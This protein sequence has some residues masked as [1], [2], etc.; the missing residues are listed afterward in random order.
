MSY[1]PQ[2]FHTVWRWTKAAS[3]LFLFALSGCSDSSD[4]TATPSNGTTP[5]EANPTAQAGSSPGVRFADCPFDLTRASSDIRCGVLDTY[6]NYELTGP[7]ARMIEV[8]FGIV[9]ATITPAAPDPIVVFMG[10]PGASGLVEFALGLE[11]SSYSG[12]RDLVLVDQRGTGYSEP[13]LNCDFPE[14]DDSNDGAILTE[15]VKDFEQQGVDLTQYRSAV[16][17][18]DFKVL[19]EALEIPQ[20]NVYG[21][22]YGPIPGVLYADLDRAGVRSVIFDSSTDNQVDIMLAD[23]ASRLDFISELAD[24]CAAETECATRLP[25]LR[26]AFIDT[27]RSLTNEP[28][29]GD[30]PDGDKFE[31]DAYALF[32]LAAD[33][34]PIAYPAFLEMF[35]NRDTEMMLQIFYADGSNDDGGNNDGDDA[36]GGNDDDD[37]N[38]GSS[39]ET[40]EDP[41]LREG[42]LLMSLTVQCAAI[43]A[44]NFYTATI[45]TKEQWPDDLLDVGRRQ[46]GEGFP[47]FCNGGYVSIEQDLSQREPRLLDVPALILGGGLDP[48]VSLHQVRTFTESFASPRLAIKPKGEHGIGFPVVDTDDCIKGI[49]ASFLDNPDVAPEMDCLTTDVE[50]FVFDDALLQL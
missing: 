50:P 42:A 15:C 21:V 23:A 7:D 47:D 2:C 27:F 30:T 28:W 29:V 33:L 18:Q 5:S 3:L 8:A 19:R 34:P 37:G 26:S 41:I 31:F 46:V 6:E 4:S 13:F 22:S 10:G 9:P 12:N 16:I 35:A 14:D 45:P 43:D 11:Y 1:L 40:L 49:A 48:I 44:P 39:A 32:D 20:W 36:V 38:Q 25:D 17:A 24:Q